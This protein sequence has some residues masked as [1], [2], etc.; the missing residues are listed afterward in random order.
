MS[1]AL[2]TQNY[3]FD[4]QGRKDPFYDMSYFCLVTCIYQIYKNAQPQAQQ[5]MYSLIDDLSVFMILNQ[6]REIEEIFT[7]EI[8]TESCNYSLEEYEGEEGLKVLHQLLEEGKPVIV[9]TV[10]ELLDFSINYTPDYDLKE[11][12]PGHVFIIL[13]FDGENYYYLEDPFAQINYDYFIPYKERK[14]IG[15]MPKEKMEAAFNG[16]LQ[17]I[18]AK[19]NLEQSHLVEERVKQSILSSVQNYYKPNENLESGKVKYTGRN[20]ICELMKLVEKGL[21]LNGSIPG[22]TTKLIGF[23]PWLCSILYKKRKLLTLGLKDLSDKYET[24][25]VAPELFECLKQSEKKWTKFKNRIE[26]NKV[27]HIESLDESYIPV[28]KEILEVEDQLNE[29]LKICLENIQF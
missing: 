25:E 14:D 22:V 21:D 6:E 24:F 23:I 15:V 5:V 12:E 27:R 4:A 7:N 29:L 19:L 10:T 8:A 28:L 20:V 1:E 9:C 2:L 26:K 13:H 16:Y 18:I 11:F 17:C 3:Y